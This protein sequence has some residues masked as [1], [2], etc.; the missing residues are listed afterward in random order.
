MTLFSTTRP[1]L[2]C[3]RVHSHRSSNRAHKR[4]F[5]RTRL[6]IY[7]NLSSN[8]STL[9][10]LTL[11][12]TTQYCNLRK[13]VVQYTHTHKHTISYTVLDSKCIVQTTYIAQAHTSC[14]QK[15]GCGAVHPHSHT[16]P[17][18]YNI[19]TVT[20]YP[21]TSCLPKN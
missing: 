20:L 5:L 7:S 2:Q 10:A 11:T 8:V 3:T 21:Q 15:K 1:S 18:T 13:V 17:P 6:S 19:P 9:Y 14:T 16:Y 12:H 4:G